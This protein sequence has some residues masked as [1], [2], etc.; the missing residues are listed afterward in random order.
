MHEGV[1]PTSGL[2][3]GMVW[4]AVAGEVASVCTARRRCLGWQPLWPLR[5]NKVVPGWT[6]ATDV[7]RYLIHKFALQCKG[8][9]QVHLTV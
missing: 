5:P 6:F 4:L 2:R 8:K 7:S 1:S 9:W 3:V